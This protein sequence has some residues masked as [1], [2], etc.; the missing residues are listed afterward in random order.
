MEETI[1]AISTPLGEGGIA[2]IRISG[3]CAFA[4]AD[5]LFVSRHGKPSTFPTHTIHFGTIV[6]DGDL[7]DQIMLSVM[8][9]PRTYTGEDTV[10]INCHGGILTAR[11]ILSACFHQGTR[12]AEPGEFT[13]R[14]FLNGRLDLTQAEAV[15]DLIHA[16]TDRAQAAAAR[17]LEGHLS[18]HINRLRDQ[19]VSVLAH[20]EAHI[21][22]PEEDIQPDT[23]AELHR[24]IIAVR[25]GLQELLA[26]AREGRILRHGIRIA[27]VGRPNAG[28]SSL[29][30]AL[31][32][33]DRS[34]VTPV[35]GTTR[36]T[37]EEYV[38]IGGI[39]IR[40]TDT[41]GLRKARGVVE[42]LGVARSRR[43]VEDSELVIHVLDASRPFSTA[44]TEIHHHTNTKNTIYVLTKIDLVR[45][46][47]L[48]AHL[49]DSKLVETSTKTGFGIS[50]LR[51]RIVT[52]AGDGSSGQSHL[53]VAINERHRDSIE[54]ALSTLV[55]AESQFLRHAGLEIVSQQIRS[56]L[57]ALGVIVGKTTT[58]DILTQI[59]SKFC[60]GK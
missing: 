58:E 36:D 46:I 4:A 31:L 54:V 60:I 2:I 21:D 20:I 44:D 8:R 18:G 6:H 14:A 43:S 13:K 47:K 23:H 48:P 25:T 12:L 33:H 10:E 52:T 16:K 39:P 38:N 37:I 34:I 26:T 50:N 17:V 24:Q 30:N 1:A 56:C 57:D 9:A 22:F 32:G 11:R 40:L 29:M 49:S 27:I 3:P 15:M 28:K 59:F 42:E 45:R 41:A 7:L 5:R 35:A 53:D 51:D 55:E 19:L